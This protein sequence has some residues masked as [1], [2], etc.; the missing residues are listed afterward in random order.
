MEV[1]EGSVFV[2]RKGSSVIGQ[3][4]RVQPKSTIP[5][6]KIAR[7][8]DTTKKVSYQPTESSVAIE[9]Y[10]E[11]DPDQLAQLLAGTTKPGGGGWAGTEK[12]FLNPTI[13]AYDLLLDQY[14]AATGTSD[15][16]VGTWTMKNFKPTSLDLNV[17]SDNPATLTINGEM[18]DFYLSPAAGLNG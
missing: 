6:K 3:A 18:E 5:T 9:I 8:G 17:Q 16:L 2:L 13:T 4:I 1:N 10:T 11:K 14:N 7:I 12:L 15:T